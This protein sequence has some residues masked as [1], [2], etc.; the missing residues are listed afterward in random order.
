MSSRARR[1]STLG[2]RIANDKGAYRGQSQ[3]QSRAGFRVTGP[4]SRL[5]SK[6]DSASRCG[7]EG[8]SGLGRSPFQAMEEYHV[9]RRHFA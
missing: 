8:L 7:L 3:W 6:V 5:Y 4:T 1:A 9:Q 2:L